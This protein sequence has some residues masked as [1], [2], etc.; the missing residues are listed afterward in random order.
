MVKEQEKRIKIL[1]NENKEKVELLQKENVQMV[2][3]DI[4]NHYEKI[5]KYL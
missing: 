1:E 5:N 4:I 2:K 3:E